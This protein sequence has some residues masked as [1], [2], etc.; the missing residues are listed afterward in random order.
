MW[1]KTKDEDE[2]KVNA[3][4]LVKNF[5]AHCLSEEARRK[6]S[7]RSIHSFG[8]KSI[9][10]LTIRDVAKQKKLEFTYTSIHKSYEDCKV[11]EIT[12]KLDRAKMLI[13]EA[14]KKLFGY[15]GLCI[16]DI[17]QNKLAA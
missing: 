7:G 14:D 11:H 17:I 12:F 3:G 2:F 5:I 1:R 13:F 15:T 6:I 9:E 4:E 16:N 8:Q 10:D